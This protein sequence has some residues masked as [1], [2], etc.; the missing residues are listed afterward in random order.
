M[1]T[2]YFNCPKCKE[3]KSVR[4]E[5]HKTRYGATGCCGATNGDLIMLRTFQWR[6]GYCGYNKVQLNINNNQ[7]V[8]TYE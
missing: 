5:E 7:E 4:F 6:C 3:K 2:R 8:V 1:Q